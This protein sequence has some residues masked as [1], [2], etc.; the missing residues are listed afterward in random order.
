M[1]ANGNSQ[2]AATSPLNQVKRSKNLNLLIPME[3]AAIF[4]VKPWVNDLI[5]SDTFETKYLYYLY[6]YLQLNYFF[7]T[8]TLKLDLL[9]ID[10]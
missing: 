1:K 6:R 5:P 8:V 2:A 10:S 4:L 9:I 7:E 3:P